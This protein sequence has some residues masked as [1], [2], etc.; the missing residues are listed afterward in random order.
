MEI[1]EILAKKIENEEYRDAYRMAWEQVP[2]DPENYELVYDMAICKEALGEVAEAYYTYRLAMILCEDGNDREVINRSFQHLCGYA[3]TSEYA[4]SEACGNLA[5]KLLSCGCIETA[6]RFLSGVLY[7]RNREAAK[8]ALS[9]G[10]M[11]QKIR[12]EILLCEKRR[13]GTEGSCQIC[14][15]TYETFF[16]KYQ[17]IKRHIR[18]IWFGF[19]VEEQKELS[20]YIRKEPVSP[21]CLAVIAKYSVPPGF[22]GDLF[23]R[24]I[25][26]L[27]A[28]HPSMAGDLRIYLQWIQK[29]NMTG[30]DLC[31]EPMERQDRFAVRILTYQKTDTHGKSAEGAEDKDPSKLA[32]IFCTNDEEYA[33]ECKSYLN[34]LRL[35]E[36]IRGEIL[37]IHDAPGMAAGYNF[38]M[39]ATDAKVKIY[40]HHDTLLI[41]PGLPGKLLH[42]FR[43]EEKLGMLGVFGSEI[44]PESGKWYQAPYEK[45]VLTLYQDAIL[46]FLL[47]KEAKIAGWKP[48]EAAD[49]A[50]LATAC[51]VPWQEESFPHWHF[52]DIAQC[53]EMRKRGLSVGLYEDTTPWILHESTLRKDPEMQYEKYCRIFLKKYK[54]G[55]KD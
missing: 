43:K 1:L 18:R 44:L 30:S 26:L 54:K 10:N 32:V 39:S 37:E 6:D 45:S 25:D 33:A 51:N 36:G 46:Q 55:V 34:Y 11:V 52:Y 15:D 12:T 49:G 35:P 31:R 50:F 42:A 17:C 23:R 5:E 27:S 29:E 4:L 41:D 16:R 47:P 53:E 28:D 19:S 40:I 8:V 14:H 13:G 22:L 24:M 2:G 3:D 20:S 7:D 21:D 48:A 38:A 9:E